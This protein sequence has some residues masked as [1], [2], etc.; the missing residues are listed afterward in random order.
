MDGERT[1]REIG[2]MIPIDDAALYQVAYAAIV[3]GAVLPRRAGD[4]RAHGGEPV[5]AA[6]RR[7]LAI[8]RQRVA[9]KHAQVR[10]GDYFSLLGLR[11]DATSHEVLRA[12][13]RMRVDFGRTAIAEEVAE[14][15]AS[16]LAEIRELIE[17]A[18]QILGDDQ[19][20]DAY[21]ES[22]EQP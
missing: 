1:L 7:D 16:E 18:F 8:D 14:E 13:E 5:P 21:R 9:A 19:L 3:L 4:I 10:E 2:G 22:L 11:P 12:Y 17:E 15:L 6:Q 20:R